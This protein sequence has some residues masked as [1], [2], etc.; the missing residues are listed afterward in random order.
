MEDLFA[1]PFTAT[2][3]RQLDDIA[4]GRGQEK[5][6]LQTLWGS[7]KERYE[8]LLSAP[9]SSSSSSSSS[10][11][12][13]PSP[14]ASS[15]KQKIFKNGLKAVQTKKGPLLLREGATKE[16]TEFFGWP[17]SLSWDKMTEQKA[18]EHVQAVTKEREPHIVTHYKDHPVVKKKGQYGF[19]LRWDTVT[20]PFVEG[21]TA[22]ALHV[23]LEQR[24]ASSSSSPSSSA[25]TTLT[26]TL[27]SSTTVIKETTHYLIRTGPYG[28]YMMKKQAASTKGKKT[29]FV[30]I[31]KG[32]DMNP[33][34]DKEI[35][36]LYKAGLEAKKNR[37]PYPSAPKGEDDE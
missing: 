36:A 6:L 21:E 34:T 9:S 1:Y 23:R 4:E 27:T 15:P 30:S 33:L 20:L 28:P 22:E 37:R 2:M 29:V 32:L 13:S 35:D 17:A 31:P 7:Y 11:S 5:T 25:S 18:V 12:S 16:Q 10:A 8:T 19:Y 26:T 24:T 3:E 14:S